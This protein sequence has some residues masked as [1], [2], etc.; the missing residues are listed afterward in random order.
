MCSPPPDLTLYWKSFTTPS[1]EGVHVYSARTS[2]CSPRPFQISLTRRQSRCQKHFFFKYT[3]VYT[4]KYCFLK[5]NY[6]FNLKNSLKKICK[7]Q[8]VL[9]AT[10]F[11][12]FLA[13]GVKNTNSFS[14]MCVC[15]CVY[16]YIYML[17]NY[18]S[19]E[20]YFFNLKNS[21]PN[22]ARTSLCC[23]LPILVSLTW[24]SSRCPKTLFNDTIFF[25]LIKK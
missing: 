20:D 1:M 19:K 14:N 17:K 18:F 7:D 25:N 4:S 2:L 12:I 13:Q 10:F 3:H 23:P 15:V 21:K 8:P 5:E 24:R 11:L 16:I 6:F 22:C 9:P